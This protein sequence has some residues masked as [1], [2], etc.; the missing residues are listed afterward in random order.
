MQGIHQYSKLMEEKLVKNQV[1]IIF[2][3]KPTEII[4]DAFMLGFME[5]KN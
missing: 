1:F 5:G 4:I 2:N 3:S